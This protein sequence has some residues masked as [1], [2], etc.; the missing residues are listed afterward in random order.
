VYVRGAY[1]EQPKHW[2]AANRL[3]T[4][5]RQTAYTL[6]RGKPEYVDVNGP[7]T[8]LGKLEHHSIADTEPLIYR[9]PSCG[10]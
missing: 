5:A 3:N 2:S 4:E 9:E 7:A 8:A 1:R 10:R 6:K